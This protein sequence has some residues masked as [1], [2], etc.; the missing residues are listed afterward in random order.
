MVRLFEYD[1]FSTVW[2]LLIQNVDF[3]ANVMPMTW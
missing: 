2:K 1:E 3:I